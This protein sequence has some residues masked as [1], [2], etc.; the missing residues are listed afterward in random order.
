MEERRAGW[1]FTCRSHWN[2]DQSLLTPLGRKGRL[3][4]L[5]IWPKWPSSNWPCN[6][7]VKG[8]NGVFTVVLTGWLHTC[9]EVALPQCLR[10]WSY[11][12]PKWQSLS[13]GFWAC[14]LNGL[15]KSSIQSLVLLSLVWVPEI[16]QISR[17]SYRTTN[18][19]LFDA[20]NR[21][22]FHQPSW[23]HCPERSEN[24]VG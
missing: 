13:S 24:C 7:S 2:Q 22:L 14:E 10:R 4:E 6:Q 8:S 11:T 18:A 9:V 16:P 20:S 5:N 19:G 23:L 21:T 1:H 17:M 15:V 3:N 12:W